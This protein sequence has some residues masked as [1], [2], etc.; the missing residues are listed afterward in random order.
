M[1]SNLLAKSLVSVTAV[2]GLT[3]GSLAGAG[4]AL[5][6]PQKAAQPPVSSEAVAP[7]AVVNLGLSAAQAR[8][9]QRW[10]TRHWGYTGAIDGQL[11]TN[12]WKAFQRNLRT[13]WGYTGAIDGVVGSGTV[14]A[15]QRLLKAGWG[16]TGAIDGIAGSGTQAAFKRFANALG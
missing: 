8:N 13:H 12:S 11:G 2:V 9:V 4:T 3:A 5:A 6:A 16:Y 1:R 7:Q 14:S 15:L 10:L